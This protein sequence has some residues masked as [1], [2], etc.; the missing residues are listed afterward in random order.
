[1]EV[2][3]ISTRPISMIFRRASLQS[4]RFP[5][6]Q[7]SDFVSFLISFWED[8]GAPREHPGTTEDQ[9]GGSWGLQGPFCVEVTFKEIQ[10]SWELICE[11]FPWQF[12]TQ[13]GGTEVE[14]M[15]GH[16]PTIHLYKKLP[17]YRPSGRH[18][19]CFLGATWGSPRPW[20]SHAWASDL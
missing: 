1:M 5:G 4:S 7:L 12:S 9:F 15:P 13:I 6:S 11:C 18:V 10:K 2:E 16:C 19:G 14:S 3:R 8:P 17:I 20:I